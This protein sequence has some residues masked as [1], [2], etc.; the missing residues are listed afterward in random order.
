MIDYDLRIRRFIQEAEDSSVALIQMDVVLGFGSHPNP[1][2][3]LAPS[4]ESV[5][6]TAEAAGRQLIV[7]LSITGTDADPQSFS[8]Q[9]DALRRAGAIVKESNA[10]ASW[11]AATC[12]A[13]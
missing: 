6:K 8:H 3:E 2:E 5:K 4:I 9:R 13:N 1:A 11:L 10:A 7:V 12:V